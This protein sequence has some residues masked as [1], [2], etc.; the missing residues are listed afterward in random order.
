M[1]PNARKFST[2]SSSVTSEERGSGKVTWMRV[3]LGSLRTRSTA[4]PTVSG[5]IWRPQSGQY[6]RPTRAQRSLR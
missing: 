3:P 1:K 6:V 5:L 4:L 2:I